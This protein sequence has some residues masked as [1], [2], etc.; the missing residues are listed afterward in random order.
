M[1]NLKFEGY[2]A[3]ATELYGQAEEFLMR[4]VREPQAGA[5]PGMDGLVDSINTGTETM[6]GLVS[7]LRMGVN[8]GPAWDSIVEETA[9]A[10]EAF[11]RELYTGAF[12]SYWQEFSG[13]A[14]K[15]L[16]TYRFV[17]FGLR[18]TK[19]SHG[20]ISSIGLSSPKSVT[21]VEDPTA[22]KMSALPKREGPYFTD[23]SGLVHVG[24]QLA[25]AVQQHK[26]KKTE[27]TGLNMSGGLKS[28]YPS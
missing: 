26:A 18:A 10:F 5:I 19:E 17:G 2:V 12:A 27:T 11:G 21:K 25:R 6:Q 28:T 14:Q 8:S 7:L 23:I 13:Q 22:I 15:D 20:N 3:M 1:V 9:G 4:V 16:L 24:L